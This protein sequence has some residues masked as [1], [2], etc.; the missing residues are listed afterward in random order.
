MSAD[1]PPTEHVWDELGRRVRN[2]VPPPANVAKLYQLLI[3]EFNNIPRLRIQNSTNASSLAS[4]HTG[5][6]WS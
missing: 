6:R 5:E 3:Q 1:I 4:M 2:R